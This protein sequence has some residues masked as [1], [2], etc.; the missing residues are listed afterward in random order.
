[1]KTTYIQPT[2]RVILLDTTDL[3]C[4]SPGLRNGPSDPT[5][6]NLG[7]SRSDDDDMEDF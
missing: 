3:I 1:M 2:F 7:R 4:T 6:M 5:Q